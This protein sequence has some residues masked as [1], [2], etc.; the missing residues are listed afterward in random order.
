MFH[1]V[2]VFILDHAM[3]RGNHPGVD[4]QRGQRFRKCA[5]Y[6]GKAA[7][8]GEGRALSGYQ[9]NIGQTVAAPLFQHLAEFFFHRILPSA[10][11][12][13]RIRA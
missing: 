13:I 11:L 4:T 5:D 6:I 9:K 2:G 3:I 8:L 10:V 1:L 7:G 12:F